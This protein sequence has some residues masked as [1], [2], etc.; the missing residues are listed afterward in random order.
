MVILWATYNSRCWFRVDL[1]HLG[2]YISGFLSIWIYLQS[3]FPWPKGIR[4][5][6]GPFPVR[7]QTWFFFGLHTALDVGSGLIWVILVP[8][9]LSSIKFYGS[10]GNSA[11]NGAFS[12]A[13]TRSSSSSSSGVMMD[14][15]SLLIG[16]CWVSEWLPLVCLV[17]SAML[18]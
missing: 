12:R 3:S 10:S 18:L 14:P 1:G 8:V 4:L 6:M 11:S 7:I 13:Y 16:E 17:G 15:A 9:D 2:L 5:Q